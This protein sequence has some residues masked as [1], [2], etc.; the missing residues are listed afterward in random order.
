MKVLISYGNYFGQGKHYQAKFIYDNTEE[1]KSIEKLTRKIGAINP[2]QENFTQGRKT[3]P[4]TVIGGTN[5]PQDI[6]LPTLNELINTHNA[7]VIIGKHEFTTFDVDS[8]TKAIDSL[9]INITLKKGTYFNFDNC[10]YVTFKYAT[11]AQREE[12][13]YDFNVN[14]NSIIGQNHQVEQSDYL[15]PFIVDR[16]GNITFK[17][18]GIIGGTNIPTQ[19]L[20]FFLIRF[21]KEYN[22]IITT[23][24]ARYKNS[25]DLEKLI[26]SLPS[27][28]Q[29]R[30]RTR[31]INQVKKGI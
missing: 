28:K 18:T 2:Y 5:I 25:E 27:S 20:P 29:G 17:N 8:I 13:S 11:D 26:E 23:D 16:N 12:V 15:F 4:I 9:H 19:A 21:I 24:N 6:I 31:S 14:L 22:A 7:T 10:Y 3:T 30:T 1:T